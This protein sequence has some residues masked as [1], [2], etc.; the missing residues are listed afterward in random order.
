MH[1]APRRSARDLFVAF[2][3]IGL[4][5]FGGALPYAHAEL[6]DRRRWLDDAEFTEILS[7]GQLLP[8]PNILNVAIFVGVRHGGRF[9]AVAAGLGLLALPMVI[10][11]A[12]GATYQTF[13]GTPGLERAIGAIAAAAAGLVIAMGLKLARSLPRRAWPWLVAATA[14]V[15]MLVMHVPLAWLVLTLAPVSMFLAAWFDPARRTRTDRR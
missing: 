15:A 6:V 5:G 12:L 11:L 9:G 3:R 2:L 4:S 10:I 7:I 8:G 14:F 13:A 1:P